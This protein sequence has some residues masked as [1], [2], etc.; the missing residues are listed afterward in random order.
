MSTKSN[1]FY[2]F[3]LDNN[4]SPKGKPPDM[5]IDVVE[6]SDVVH[7]N[8]SIANGETKSPVS[9]KPI[10]PVPVSLFLFIY[11]RIMI[12]QANYSRW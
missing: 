6:A 1:V 3:Y 8:N 5:E 7:K 2:S 12:H 10:E 4:K 11:S 9:N